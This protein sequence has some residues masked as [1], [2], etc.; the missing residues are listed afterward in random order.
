MELKTVAKILEGGF[1]TEASSFIEEKEV[2]FC[3]GSDLMSDV[4]AFSHQDTL[5]CTGLI[6]MQVVRTADISGLSAL[7][8]VRNK[9]PSRE[10][11]QAAEEIGLPVIG[12]GFSM[13]EVCGR[14]YSNGLKGCYENSNE[15]NQAD[16][17]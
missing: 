13:F 2:D 16:I 9:K 14:L 3:C 17:N 10:F 4:L 11:L 1:L 7:V 12:T 6:N 8:I 15:K 5:L